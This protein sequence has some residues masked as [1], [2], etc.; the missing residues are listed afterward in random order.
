MQFPTMIEL[1]FI[2]H[3]LYYVNI[4]NLRKLSKQNLKI[5]VT[6]KTTLNSEFTSPKQNCLENGTKLQGKT[7]LRSSQLDL[8]P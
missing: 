4:Q 6:S 1:E 5:Y 7:K 3:A 2:S 8:I